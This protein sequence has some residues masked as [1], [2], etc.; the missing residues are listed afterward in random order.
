[1]KKIQDYRF[2]VNPLGPSSKAKAVIRGLARKVDRVPGDHLERF[3]RYVSR[4][5]GVPG[6][7]IIPAPGTTHL[8][9][10]LLRME[11]VRLLAAVA[12][13]SSMRL[14]VLD[15][16]DIAVRLIRQ[17]GQI[18]GEGAAPG[19]MKALS[20]AGALLVPV[21]HDVT[22]YTMP[23]HELETVIDR[24]RLEGKMIIIDGSLADFPGLA[25]PVEKAVSLPGVIILRGF[26]SFHALAGLR[27][28][29]G[30]ASPPLIER[31]RNH[32]VETGVSSVALD[33]ARASLG[34]KGYGTRSRAFVAGEKTFIQKGLKDL[35]GVTV[36]DTS[37]S[38]L[39]L[40]LEVKETDLTGW[41]RK[42]GLLFEMWSEPPGVVMRLPVLRRKENARIVRFIRQAVRITHGSR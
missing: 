24:A 12:P 20:R 7:C 19:L 41:L 30:I 4:R 23:S 21:P 34:D 3:I 16:S 22:G 14:P 36:T 17:D 26:S 25:L 1:M 28:A 31:L 11:G 6:E 33:A 9:E 37:C 40:R 27:I 29:Y 35:A 5:E 42:E 39:L 2:P 32:G 10:T 18:P 15:R 38:F 13:F 8:I